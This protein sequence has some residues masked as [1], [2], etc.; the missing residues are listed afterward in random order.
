MLVLPIQN[1]LFFV[2]PLFRIGASNSFLNV[3]LCT[4]GIGYGRAWYGLT[5]SFK[6]NSTGDVFHSP[7]FLQ[8]GT[9]VSLVI[10]LTTCTF[11]FC[12]MCTMRPLLYLYL[13]FHILHLRCD[14]Y[15]VSLH[16]GSHFLSIRNNHLHL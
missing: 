1:Y 9:H 3:A 16:L 11:I 7:V 6:F 12:Q 14:A 10:Y 5:S 15:V 13:V 2:V 4:C 8:I